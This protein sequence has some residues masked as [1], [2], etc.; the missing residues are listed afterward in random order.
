MSYSPLERG[1][2]RARA[3]AVAVLAQVDALPGAERQAPVADRQRQRRAEQRGLDVRRHV[4][5]ALE[6]VRPERRVLGHR[7]VE[8]RLEVAPHVGRGV[9]VE[10]QRR[11]RVL[12]QQVREPD[13]QLAQ[14]RQRVEH[15][16]RDEMEAAPARLERDLALDPHGGDRLD[17]MER[18]GWSGRSVRSGRRLR[19][20]VGCRGGPGRA[21]YGGRR[22]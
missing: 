6:R 3:A 22:P 9:L 12:E 2:Q 5:G 16:A 15:L 4:V 8:P 10:R 13:P 21:T 1:D 11:R 17:R 14:L 18:P 20:C 19:I 7:V